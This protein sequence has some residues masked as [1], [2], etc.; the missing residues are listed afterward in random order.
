MSNLSDV[1]ESVTEDHG[2]DAAVVITSNGDVSNIG[3][4]ISEDVAEHP[5]ERSLWML[6]LHIDHIRRTS[7]A[8]GGNATVEDVVTD[9]LKLLEAHYEEPADE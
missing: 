8:A 2:T 9:A 6:A 5:I 1:A 3:G 7:H 4:H